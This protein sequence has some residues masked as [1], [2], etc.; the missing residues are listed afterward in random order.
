MDEYYARKTFKNISG[1]VAREQR[2]RA[3]TK[4]TTKQKA[5]SS[6]KSDKRR[7]YN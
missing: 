5:V 1:V 6:Y 2:A 7:R 4:P 3:L